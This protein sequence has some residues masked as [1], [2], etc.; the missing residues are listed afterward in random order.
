MATHS[1]ILAWRIPMDRGVWRATICGVA[2]SD[3]AERLSTALCAQPS[4]G[5]QRGSPVTKRGCSVTA[6]STA[7]GP[8]AEQRLRWSLLPHCPPNPLNFNQGL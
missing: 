3:T 1:V 7:W 6:Q 2:E 4:A 5:G 8:L